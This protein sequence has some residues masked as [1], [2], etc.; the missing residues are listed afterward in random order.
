MFNFFKRKK[1]KDTERD[2]QDKSVIKG[3]TGITA[4]HSAK[5][6][7]DEASKTFAKPEKYTGNRNL[8]DSGKAKQVAKMEAF[9]DGTTVI[10]PYT[11]D[12]LYLRKS[13]AVL[14]G[15][16]SA[17]KNVAESDHITPIEK[18]FKDHKKNAWI[19][20]DDIKDI[21]NSRENIEVVSRKYN[22]AK[23]S[24]TN[25]EL[26]TD[27]K[28]LKKTGVTL[29]EEGKR[30]AIQTGKKSQA[31][32]KKQVRQTAIGNIIK[33]GHQAGRNA[34][35]NTG[36]MAVTI[37]GIRN[38]TSVIKGEKSVEEALEDTVVD[39]G[40]AAATGYLMGGGLTTISHS[41]SSSSSQFLQALFKSDVPGNII[42]AVMVTGD[43]LRRYGNGE[44]STQE[45]LIELGD[46]G[47]NVATAGY[48]AA[49]GQALIPIPVVGAAVGAL[50]GSTMTSK[51]YN[52]LIMKLKTKQ[53][54]H[55]ERMRIAAECEQV[56]REA[57]AYRDELEG[58]MEKYFADYKNCFSESLSEI[59]NA[60]HAGDADAVIAGTNK[61]TR[62][63]G[64]NIYYETVKEFEDYLADDS[65][66]IL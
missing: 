17:L 34:A 2:E 40:K 54:E 50:V 3:A 9:K 13:D 52:E 51:Y 37:S 33:T 31:T 20:N 32:I 30:K 63:L 15:G 28:Y 16:K 23:R 64:G 38:I 11:G 21:A 12:K 27:D 61:I 45:C 8:Y 22:N 29:S 39:T 26:V 56:A 66:D 49:V 43:T 62:K 46:K 47:L 35:Q 60:F 14:K 42:T 19:S 53:L 58:Y 57:R 65:V 44:I 6:S 24:R 5:T 1:S 7:I 41:L 36:T 59:H 4:T 10:D 25:E 48:S 55:E 18:I